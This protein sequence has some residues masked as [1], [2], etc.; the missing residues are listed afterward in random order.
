MQIVTLQAHFDGRHI[1][2]DEPYE[3]EPNTKLVIS[4]IDMKDESDFWQAA[5]SSSLD[6]IWDN[7]E[8]DVY[9]EL[10]EA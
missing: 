2:L 7:T 4:V 5:S 9:A 10:L 8:D 1:L 3:L 6:D